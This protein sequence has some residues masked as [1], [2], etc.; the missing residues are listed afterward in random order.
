VKYFHTNTITGLR[1]ASLLLREIKEGIYVEQIAE[2]IAQKKVKIVVEPAPVE[3]QLLRFTVRFDSDELNEAAARDEL[4]CEWDF[5]HNNLKETGWEAFH[6]FPPPWRGFRGWLWRLWRGLWPW[7]KRE[8]NPYPITATFSKRFPDPNDPPPLVLPD[9]IMVSEPPESGSADRNLAEGVRLGIAL[10]IALI[11]LLAG[12]REQLT[13][14]DLIPAAIAVF[15][16]GFGADTI[17]N[18]ISPK[19]AQPET[20]RPRS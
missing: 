12:A 5:G 10:V 18:L 9:E 6:Y 16:L 8:S 7:R 2:A 11:G 20:A 4:R 19:Q 1:R 13:K 3:D 17:K 14:L 15:L